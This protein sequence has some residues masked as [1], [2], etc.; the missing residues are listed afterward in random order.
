M[1]GCT[2][3]AYAANYST[4]WG[5]PFGRAARPNPE[6]SPV[7]P[8]PVPP[9]CPRP[10]AP[11]AASAAVASAQRYREKSRMQREGMHTN[12]PHQLLVGLEPRVRKRAQERNV[13]A[14][15]LPSKATRM[16]HAG[17]SVGML[18]CLHPPLASYRQRRGA[19]LYMQP[20][21]FRA[22]A[23]PWLLPWRRAQTYRGGRAPLGAYQRHACESA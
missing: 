6:I 5:G 4:C 15:A 17:C 19:K 16:L 12:L 11:F 7:R 21:P 20:M 3:R 18:G 23:A 2:L 22:A 9:R 14:T 10:A 8:P 1:L 13:Q